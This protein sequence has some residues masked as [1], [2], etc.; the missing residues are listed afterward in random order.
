MISCQNGNRQI[1]DGQSKAS[2]YNTK[3]CVSRSIYHWKTT[4]DL[5]PADYLLIKNHNIKKLYI[6][7]FDVDRDF[8]EQNMRCEA[9]PIASTVFKSAIPKG[10]EVIPAVYI[11]LTA[12]QDSETHMESFAK[13]IVQ[14]ILNMCSYNY[15]GKIKEIHIDCD[16]TKSTKKQF[17]YLC[18]MIRQA[19]S[20]K[21]LDIKLSG[22]IRLH[23]LEEAEYPFDMG[24]LM[25]Y[26]T[27]AVMNKMTMNSILD[28]NDAYKYLSVNSRI[29][30]FI[31]A[32]KHNCPIIDVAYPTY[33]WGVV[34]YNNCFRRLVKNP[35]KYELQEGETIRIEKSDIETILR[36]KNLVD[37][38]IGK[39]IRSNI[40]YHLDSNNL[41]KYSY[42][43]IEK[44]YN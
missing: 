33:S 5:S 20:L 3:D 41:N 18:S 19:I 40:I 35:E 39:V 16:W 13:R 2:V 9:I 1:T 27:G 32:R 11:T 21:E 14:R 31:Q 30:K 42:D 25:M 26:N 8:N 22:T 15:L 29:K 12:L 38:K 6:R 7:M 10:V 37:K 23:Q 4:F 43:E 36:V 34:F 24:V 44:I 28:Y 17:F